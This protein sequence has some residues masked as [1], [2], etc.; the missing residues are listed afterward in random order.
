MPSRVE[1]GHGH[2][3]G[4]HARAAGAEAARAALAGL[5]QPPSL[6]LVFASAYGDPAA[7]L[8]GVREVT[9]EAPL[10]GLSTEREID[11]ADLVGAVAVAALATDALTVRLGV[12]PRGGRALEPALDEALGAAGGAPY[13]GG[14]G[15]WLEATR[16]GRAVFAF[17]LASGEG[18]GGAGRLAEQLTRR[19]GGRLPVFAFASASAPAAPGVVLAGDRVLDDGV[20]FALVETTLEVGFAAAADGQALH[21]AVLRGRVTD[22]VL[23]LTAVRG[24]PRPRAAPDEVATMAAAL[25]GVP[26]VGFRAPAGAP[27]VTTLVLGRDLSREAQ[28]AEQNALLLER[29][30][31]GEAQ[32]RALLDSIPDLAWMKDV[33]GRLA[34]VNQPFAAFVGR[35]REE[36]LGQRG[37]EVLPPALAAAGGGG[38]RSEGASTREELRVADAAG[39]PVWLEALQAPVRDE[40]GRV[41]GTAGVARD[42]TW[43]RELEELRHAANDELERLV[44]RRTSELAESEERYRMLVRGTPNSAVFLVDAELRCTLAEGTLVE[45]I[46]PAGGVVGRRLDA[47]PEHAGGPIEAALRRALA[48]ETVELEAV[49]GKLLVLLHAAPFRSKGGGSTAAMLVATDVSERRRLEEQVRQAQKMEAIGRLAGGIAHDFNNILTVILGSARDL[50]RSA[51]G[52]EARELAQEV[53]DAGDRAAALTRQLLAFSRQ[54]ALRPRELDVNEVV[55]DLEKM[56]RRL[57]G[58]HIAVTSALA[59]GRAAVRADPG[60]LE[61]VILNLVVNAR[62]AMPGGGRLTL[63]TALVDGAPGDAQRPPTPGP[64]VLLTVR[65]TGR[66]MSA[67][68]L[69]HLFEPFFTTKERGKGTGLGLATVYGVVQQSGGAV[70]VRSA[71][72]A[73]TTFEIYLPRLPEDEDRAADD[74]GAASS[75]ERRPRGHETVLLVEDDLA[76]RTL[77]RRILEG[78]GYR[79]VEARQPAEALVGAR[80]QA[81][82][83]LLTDVV[84]PGMGGPELAAELLAIQPALRV[85]YVSGYTENEA[86]RSGALPEGQAFLQKPFTGD[87]LARAVRETLDVPLAA[88]AARC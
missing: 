73:G 23:A 42:V 63:S 81:P 39:R 86:L 47:S 59:P 10:V 17:L 46:A 80:A 5:E 76:V 55:R 12:V 69:E 8:A 18:S 51:G 30:R 60:Q 32:V 20:A 57:I 64:H 38:A 62:D 6:V 43:R 4:G 21:D 67:E 2:A 66:G 33:E 3:L 36:L 14:P 54:Q 49:V 77:M 85:L 83:L 27:G 41:T 22:P 28:V 71:P 34:A 87:E 29:A 24:A 79:V 35:P 44:R 31:R 53:L 72:D 40:Q 75:G 84:M 9:G 58:E 88:A 15:P 61:Q 78:A 45:R 65:D 37:V 7:A 11:G 56:V 26:L 74:E 50:Y 13:L 1:V 25:G 16:A 68:V 82:D 19:S 52:A 48:G 70:A